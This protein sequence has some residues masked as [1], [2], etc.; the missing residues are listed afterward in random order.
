MEKKTTW[1]T[2]DVW[3]VLKLFTGMGVKH[4]KVALEG[5]SVQLHEPDLEVQAGVFWGTPEVLAVDT[6]GLPILGRDVTATTDRL[7]GAT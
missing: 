7:L 4:Q 6:D 5:S 2:A 1:S 3:R